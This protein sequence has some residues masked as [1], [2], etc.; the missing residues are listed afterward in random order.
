[1][2][3]GKL[4]SEAAVNPLVVFYDIHGRR[5]E[6]FSFIMSQ[7]ATQMS[8]D[9]TILYATFEDLNGPA[10]A[11]AKQRSQWSVIG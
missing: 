6:G 3:G 10:V 1:V 2:T 7:D 9:Q 8:R 5:G 11:K 4:I